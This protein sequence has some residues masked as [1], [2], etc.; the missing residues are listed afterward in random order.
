MKAGTWRLNG[1]GNMYLF[2]PDFVNLFC[3]S[4]AKMPH[5]MTLIGKT[6]YTLACSTHTLERLR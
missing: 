1:I 6:R 4:G 3:F 5:K 2:D